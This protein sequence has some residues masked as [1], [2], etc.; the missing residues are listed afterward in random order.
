M[1]GIK[2]Y[3]Y[4][5]FEVIFDLLKETFLHLSFFRSILSSRIAS[6]TSKTSIYACLVIFHLELFYCATFTYSTK[7]QKNL[8]KEAQ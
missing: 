3:N 6:I 2:A 5:W 8:R 4:N 1:L 7:K